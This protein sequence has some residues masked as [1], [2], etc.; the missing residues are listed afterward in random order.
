MICI[1][2]GAIYKAGKI[3]RLIKQIGKKT[4]LFKKKMAKFLKFIL[5]GK[6]QV[7]VFKTLR[8]VMGIFFLIK[9]T[10]GFLISL[11]FIRNSSLNFFNSFP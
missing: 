5:I 7:E 8:Q 6:Y 2:L 3:Y 1:W 11:L 9:A 4:Q 10:K